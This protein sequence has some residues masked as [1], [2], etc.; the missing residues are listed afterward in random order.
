MLRYSSGACACTYTVDRAEKLFQINSFASMVFVMFSNRS[1]TNACFR[2]KSKKK[3]CSKRETTGGF[4]GVLYRQ[5]K[6][7][8]NS[9]VFEH[10]YSVMV[11]I[12]ESDSR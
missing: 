12:C 6:E 8:E 3:Y 10:V 5:Y 9:K 1:S 4:Y 7:T 2:S 11:E